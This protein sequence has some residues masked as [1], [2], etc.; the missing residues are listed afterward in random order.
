MGIKSSGKIRND[1]MRTRA[2]VANVSENIREA[3]LRRLGH[4]ERKTEEDLVMRTWKMEVGGPKDTDT[5]TEV[6]R[7]YKKIHEGE[8]SNIE[9]AHYRRLRRLKTRCAGPK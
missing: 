3:R 7:Y 2:G 5:E 9:E 8:R 4:V 1:E 6:E